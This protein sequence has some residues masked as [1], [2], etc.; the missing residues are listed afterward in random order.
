M[1]SPWTPLHMMATSSRTNGFTDDD[2]LRLDWLPDEVLEG[3]L[4]EAGV[5]V[6][7]SYAT[8]CAAA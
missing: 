1:L 4:F 8:C 5:A 3:V 2:T 6:G 7:F